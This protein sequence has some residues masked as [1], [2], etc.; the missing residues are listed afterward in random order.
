M[1]PHRRSPKSL[2]YVFRQQG[3]SDM[4]FYAGD[5]LIR[6]YSQWYDLLHGNSKKICIITTIQNNAT[7]VV[8]MY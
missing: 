2:L 6:S 4:L 1:E 8:L 7:T 3:L 5:K